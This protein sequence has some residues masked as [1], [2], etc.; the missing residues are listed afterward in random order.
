MLEVRR[1]SKRFGGLTALDAIDLTADRGEVVAVIGP[2]GA[3]KSTA[4][5]I[6]AGLLSPSSCERL[7]VDGHE[8]GALPAHRRR[9]L[10]VALVE[11]L[12]RR[13]TSMTV[14]EDVAV[15]AIFGMPDDRSSAL[16]AADE[17]LERVGL[18]GERDLPVTALS[19]PR[20]RAL[21]L[22]RALAGRPRLLLLDEPAAGLSA[23]DLQRHLALVGALRAEGL[24]IVW[25]E[26]LVSAVAAAADRVVMLDGGRVLAEGRPAHVLRDETVVR[27]YLGHRWGER[28]A[29]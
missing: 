12:P 7:A 28:G 16:L 6:V 1:L 29:S 18:A 14:R 19:L 27:A 10:G 17:A 22:A 11:Q 13:F 5:R 21:A 8:V 3:G 9:R 20:Q 15:G 4:L 25:V 23:G 2:N 24:A 26:H